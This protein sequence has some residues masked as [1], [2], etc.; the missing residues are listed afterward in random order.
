MWFTFA[1]TLGG[2]GSIIGAFR[3]TVH[4]AC[5][6]RVQRSSCGASGRDPMLAARGANRF[7]GKP[8]PAA[9]RA[10]HAFQGRPSWDEPDGQDGDNLALCAYRASAIWPRTMH[11]P[12]RPV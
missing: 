10:G 1:A 4:V 6:G 9:A 8:P 5:A 12:V 7:D 2:L 11:L 3:L